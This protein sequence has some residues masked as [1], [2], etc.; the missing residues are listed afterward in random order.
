MLY[1]PGDIIIYGKLFDQYCLYL[2]NT[3]NRNMKVYFQDNRVNITAYIDIKQYNLF[4]DIF[5]ELTNG[6][7]NGKN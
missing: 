5:R 4:T 2:N 1:T 7:Q 3:Y 6:E